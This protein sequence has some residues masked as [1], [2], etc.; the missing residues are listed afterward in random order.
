[1]LLRSC[2]D[3]FIIP[4]APSFLPSFFP[5][6]R[7]S[8]IFSLSGYLDLEEFGQ[9]TYLILRGSFYGAVNNSDI[10]PNGMMNSKKLKNKKESYQI[11]VAP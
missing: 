2:T 8:I 3:L 9:W 7:L 5:A 11:E 6:F 1:M 4:P 10:E